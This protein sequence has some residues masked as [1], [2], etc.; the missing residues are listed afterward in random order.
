MEEWKDIEGYEGLYQVSNIGKI[1]RGNKILKQTENRCGYNYICLSKAGKKSHLLVNRIVAK[2]FI[3]NPQ[4]KPCVNHIDLNKQNNSANNLEWVTYKE[5][6]EWSVKKG[7]WHGRYK[8]MPVKA[9]NVK[10][11]EVLYFKSLMRAEANG[12]DATSISRCCKGERKTHKGYRW[13]YA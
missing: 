1:R 10:T 3:P 9:T 13:E 2:T 8:E 7:K 11:R 5:N 12:Y 6:V 4:N